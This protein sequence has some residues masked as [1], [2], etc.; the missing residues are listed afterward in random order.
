[1]KVAIFYKNTDELHQA[2]AEYKENTEL[3]A[4]VAQYHNVRNIINMY[5]NDNV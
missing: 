4:F 2:I 3:K 1:M 5:D